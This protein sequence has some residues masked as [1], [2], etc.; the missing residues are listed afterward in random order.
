MEHTLHTLS[1][2]IL[3]QL[4]QVGVILLASSF[5]RLCSEILS[6]KPD[7]TELVGSGAGN[8]T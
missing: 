3:L 6:S 2:L 1:N 8:E 7:A 5:I 4:C